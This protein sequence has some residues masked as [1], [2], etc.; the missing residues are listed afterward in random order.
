[1]VSTRIWN[2]ALIYLIH[3]MLFC[4][5]H[6]TTIRLFCW[7]LTNTPCTLFTQRLLIWQGYVTNWVLSKMKNINYHSHPNHTSGCATNQNS[8]FIVQH[9]KVEDGNQSKKVSLQYLQAL[10]CSIWTIY[11]YNNMGTKDTGSQAKPEISLAHPGTSTE[12][13]GKLICIR[14]SHYPTCPFT[15]S[16]KQF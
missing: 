14:W 3:K 5:N 12:L 2:I 9:E 4:L 6:K 8:S 10:I 7:R 16:N 15:T 13:G 11:F 1:M